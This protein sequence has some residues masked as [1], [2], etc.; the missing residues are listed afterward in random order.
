VKRRPPQTHLTAA[1]R[2]R[3]GERPLRI[4]AAE[5]GCA[6]ATLCALELDRLRPASE[7][8]S[9]LAPWLG[10]TVEQ[11]FEAA[12]QPAREPP[13]DGPHTELRKL[14]DELT[15][16]DARLLVILARRLKGGVQ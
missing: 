13:P 5:I 16:D 1:I 12:Q 4:A 9:K 15:A 14:I 8:A 7:L 11:V 2:E 3:R 6:I 10:W